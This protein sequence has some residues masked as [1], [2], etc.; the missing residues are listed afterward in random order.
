M[1]LFPKAVWEMWAS[2]PHLQE[3][4]KELKSKSQDS[5]DFCQKFSGNKEKAGTSWFLENN[6]FID[7]MVSAI[8][9]LVQAWQKKVESF[10]FHS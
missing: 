10:L 5:G 8:P 7:N 6:T 4:K 9:P 2:S 3:K 1:S